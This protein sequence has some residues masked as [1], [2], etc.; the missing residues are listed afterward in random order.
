MNLNSTGNYKGITKLKVD[1][2]EK[3]DNIGKYNKFNSYKA[4]RLFVANIV[5]NLNYHKDNFDGGKFKDI[6]R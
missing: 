4:K 1:L 2:E 3:A 5:G 6:K